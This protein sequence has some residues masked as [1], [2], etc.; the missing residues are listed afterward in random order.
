MVSESYSKPWDSEIMLN[1]ILQKPIV[2]EL[3]KFQSAI[4][5]IFPWNGV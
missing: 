3:S 4:P 5:N 1:R 2:Y